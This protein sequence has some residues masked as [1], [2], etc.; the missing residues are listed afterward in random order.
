VTPAARFGVRKKHAIRGWLLVMAVTASVT[1]EAG[2][3][4]SASAVPPPPLAASAS[5]RVTILSAEFERLWGAAATQVVAL[6]GEPLVE[7]PSFGLVSFSVD[8]ATIVTSGSIRN[9]ESLKRKVLNRSDVLSTLVAT[10][11]WGSETISQVGPEFEGQL[12]RALNDV[13]HGS[14]LPTGGSEG[15]VEGDGRF[16]SVS[17][18]NRRIAEGLYR[19][20]LIKEP[21][22][23]RPPE[24]AVVYCNVLIRSEGPNKWGVYVAAFRHGGG[25]AGMWDAVI[26]RGIE[27]EARGR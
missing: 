14:P 15:A 27:R 12:L 24:E 6:Y 19:D 11:L 20:E 21:L 22:L 7:N 16:V 9:L 4:I 10:K 5:R 3:S 2:C 17:R 13:I 8:S 1:I 23:G 26:I 18:A 25:D